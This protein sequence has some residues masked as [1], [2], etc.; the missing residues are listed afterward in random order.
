MDADFEHPPELV[1]Q[2]VEQWR[3]GF[4]IVAAQRHRTTSRCRASSARP[5]GSTIVLL[6]ALG[7]V[8]MEPGSADF[9]LLDRAVVD[10][11]NGFENQDLFLR[12]LVRWLGFPIA[13]VELPARAAA[14]RRQQILDAAG[15]SSSR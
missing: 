2:L 3:A 8:Q 7:D 10:T 12:G 9:L 11:I 4:K 15:W 14:A 1:P 13:K 5:R 6:G